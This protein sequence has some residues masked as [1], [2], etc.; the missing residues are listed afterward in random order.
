MLFQSKISPSLIKLTAILASFL[1]LTESN[2]RAAAELLLLDAALVEQRVIAVGERGTIIYS[3]DDGES[4][5]PA[6]IPAQT[7]LYNAVFF[8]D[9]H[10][11]WIVGEK[12]V[13][14]HTKNQGRSWIIQRR[15]EYSDLQLFD[16]WF[17]DP[18]FGIAVGSFG[19]VLTTNDGGNIWKEAV[20]GDS[21][22]H[23]YG[24][25]GSTDGPITI[26]GERGAI[27]QSTNEGVSWER[28]DLQLS[29]SLFGI[30]ETNHGSILTWGLGGAL[31]YFDPKTDKW[32][33]LK[34]PTEKS[35]FGGTVLK[36]GR[37]LLTGQDG[38]LILLSTL[39][40]KLSEHRTEDSTFSSTAI[41]T[42]SG[43]I[44]VLGS[45]GANVHFLTKADDT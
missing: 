1:F 15:A 7:H 2:T 11:G 16:I 20:V 40:L 37:Y 45:R 18:Q 17:R 38:C 27:F 8:P 35:L 5:Q 34:K 42:P 30:A 32:L 3:D 29:E 19:R 6:N 36:N 23:L 12:G 31:A 28:I 33:A 43:K 24:I 39:G 10:N 13:I 4:W 22:P 21:G 25:T 9:Q 41:Q 14:L 44:L 26:A